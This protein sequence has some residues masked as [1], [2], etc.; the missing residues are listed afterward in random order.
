MLER[1]AGFAH[2]RARR[3]VVGAL[4]LGLVAGALGGNVAKR[5]GPYSAKDPASESFKASQRLNQATRLDNPLLVALVTPG[6]PVRSRAGRARVLAVARELASDPALRRVA[7]P[8]TGGP[9]GTISRD[10]RSALVTAIIDGSRGTTAEIDRVVARFA[11]RPD[12][13]LGGGGAAERAANKIVSAD[14]ARA[15]LIAFPILFLLALWF[16]RSMVAAALPPLVGGLSIVI[17]FLGLR[18]ASEA[19]DLSV[20]ALN[21]VT[22]LGLGL[23]IDYSL[24][25]VSRYREE[26]AATGPGLPALV[27]TM[28]TAGR[29]V[30]FSSLTVAAALASLLVFPQRF[31]YSM[32]VGGTM[33]ALI[34][35]VIAL[36]VLPAVLVALGERVNALAPA[37]LRRAA[38]SEAR[39]ASTG[40]WYRLSRVVMRRPAPVALVAGAIMIALGL[41][42]LGVRFTSIDPSILP[43][44]ERAR[45]V[46]DALHSRFP[47]DISTAMTVVAA[48]PDAAGAQRLAARLGRLPDVALV[49][50]PERAG[51]RLWRIGLLSKARALDE[52]SQRL[53]RRIR[54][55]PAPFYVAVTGQTAAL[56]DEKSS[57]GAH[58]PLA[59][60]I[61]AT[62]TLLI[63]FAFTGSV[64]L[65]VKTLVMNLLTLSAAFGLLV[66][67]FQDGRLEGL[68][69]YRSQGAL[70]ASQPLL[71]LALAFGLSTDYGVFLLS[72]IKEARE[73]GLPDSEAIA[74]GLERTG[75]IVTAAALLF[76]VAIGA[77]A[78]SRIVFI[79]EVGVG[80]AVAVLLDATIVR[81]LLVPSLMQLL[82]RRNWWAPGPLRRL[83]A[84]VGLRESADPP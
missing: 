50:R 78:T 75:R 25:V 35:A 3:I 58:L 67:I 28:N 71:L 17:T 77:F 1:V 5:L 9:P 45:Q 81:A 11:H 10:G 82:G 55:L 8:F 63:L 41:P 70:E 16:F 84:R 52:R 40:T 15:E 64:V 54:S 74:V 31:L 46:D 61:L 56:V 42:F 14:L 33:V 24:F 19:V 69:A 83:H 2:R 66:L 68:L 39:P 20:F 47:L 34:A 23:A 12:V 13:K 62:T 72:R 65:P 60:A 29:T 22:G 36:V 26:M 53:V 21:L 43:S 76:C 32:A 49:N 18:I 7:T 38:E 27:R 80:T 30:L 44:S 4:V 37:R 48:A 73:R 79:K 6:S 59:L 51:P 57:L